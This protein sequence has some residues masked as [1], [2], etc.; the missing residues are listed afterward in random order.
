MLALLLRP[1]A[2]S[3]PAPV[4]DPLAMPAPVER[5]QDV[6][7]TPEIVRLGFWNPFHGKR[8]FLP[9]KGDAYQDKNVELGS[10]IS[11]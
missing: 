1:G 3:P 10:C 2:R 8:H 11:L 5:E 7:E 6:L 9:Q 4:R